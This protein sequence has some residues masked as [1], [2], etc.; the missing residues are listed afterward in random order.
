MAVNPTYAGPIQ[1]KP[2][3]AADPGPIQQ[4]PTTDPAQQINQAMQQTPA[5]VATQTQTPA[6]SQ[7]N[8][9][10][11]RQLLTSAAPPVQQAAKQ[12]H[13][14][15]QPAIQQTRADAQ[16]AQEATGRVYPVGANGQAPKGLRVGDQVVTAN[17]TY[18][19]VA[20]N[21]DGTYRTRLTNANQNTNNYTAAAL[22]AF[23]KPAAGVDYTAEIQKAVAAGDLGAAATLEQLRNAQILA[24]GAETPT[25]ND[26]A[27]YIG[28]ISPEYQAQ[29]VNGYTADK[30]SPG[31]K[32]QSLLEQWRAQANAQAQNQI[33]YATQK[34]INELQRAQE[35]AQ[36]EFQKQLDQNDIDTARALSNSA[37][38]AETRGDR[39]G[40]G[41]S[42]FNEIQA[43]ALKNRQS[44]NNARTKLATDTARQIADLRAQGEFEMA[45]Q[46]LTV[47]Q[48]YLSKAMELEQWNAQYMMS[49]EEMAREL[50]QWEKQFELQVANITGY[51]KG[52]L[53][54][55]AAN[56]ERDRKADVA[57][58][59]LK[60]GI[61]PSDDQLTALGMS[62]D[63]A[64]SYIWALTMGGYVGGGS[65]GGGGGSSRGSGSGGGSGA[66]EAASDSLAGW[67]ND[68]TSAAKTAAASAISNA[69]SRAFGGSGG[70][71]SSGG[72]SS[73]GS[74]GSSGRSAWPTSGGSGV[75]SSPATATKSQTDNSSSQATPRKNPTK[76][77]K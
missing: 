66:P 33:D 21:D 58:A 56:D 37:L 16:T 77:T 15:V 40:I 44:I 76:G 49:Q 43:A 27:A 75:I 11:I 2:T 61:M 45:D 24:A 22:P 55:S 60:A 23:A 30:T 13:Q 38:Y 72:S 8:L 29:L 10:Q 68:I 57:Q 18:T 3:Q 32:I 6:Q 46:L 50:E 42:Q 73:S 62:R 71:S 69:F 74:S 65:G 7:A 59:L 35:D 12:T 20:I 26:Y 67:K 19:V 1:Q 36:P 28:N 17:G 54:R 64:Q 5:P 48:Q 63:Q 14:N 34:G 9:D 25:T 52:E 41:Q 39:G 31:T 51:Y 47:S 4:K 53:T 70:N